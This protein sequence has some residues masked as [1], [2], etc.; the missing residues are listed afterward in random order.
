MRKF[1]ITCL[2]FGTLF[3]LYDKVFLIVRDYFPINHGGDQ[4]LSLLLEGKLNKDVVIIGSSRGESSIN[5]KILEDSLNIDCYNLSYRGASPEFQLFVLNEYLKRN[6][7]P[8]LVI[9]VIDD[10]F[11]LDK[12]DTLTSDRYFR[13]DILTPLVRYGVIREK[14]IEKGEKNLI[15]SN[16]FVLHQISKTNLNFLPP[17]KKSTEYGTLPMEGVMKKTTFDDSQIFEY[18]KELES[19]KQLESLM[20]IQKLCNDNDIELILATSVGFRNQNFKWL[21][22]IT[23]LISDKTFFFDFGINKDFSNY[24]DYGHLNEKGSEIYTNKLIQFINSRSIL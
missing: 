23:E 17:K 8:K 3:F 20:Y 11:E 18:E 7:E 21:E 2:I 13:N 16:L 24:F 14:M 5:V 1:L 19:P 6:N 22:R 4:R 15:L 9:K 12:A 10:D